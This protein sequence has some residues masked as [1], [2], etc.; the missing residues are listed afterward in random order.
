[1]LLLLLLLRLLLP[2]M[3]LK[4]GAG[5]SGAQ[6][7]CTS[8][9]NSSNASS[10][11]VSAVSTPVNARLPADRHEAEASDVVLMRSTQDAP[12]AAVAPDPRSCVKK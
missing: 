2:L 10:T 11:F 12:A 5:L 7:L 3:L 8:L 1:M 6:K 4:A 9:P